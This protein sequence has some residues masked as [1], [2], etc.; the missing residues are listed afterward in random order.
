MFFEVKVKS[1]K[2]DSRK[3]TSVF[4]VKVKSRNLV[5][6]KIASVFLLKPEILQVPYV[7][8]QVNKF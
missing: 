6:R 5:S 8:T 1:W 7:I 4:E 2:L 3:I